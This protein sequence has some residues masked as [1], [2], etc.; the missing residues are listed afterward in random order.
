MEEFRFIL[1]RRV[2]IVLLSLVVFIGAF[3]A[4][5]AAGRALA[6]RPSPVDQE[7]SAASTD[8]VA[9]EALILAPSSPPIIVNSAIDTLVQE[10]HT[11]YGS[12]SVDRAYS[13]TT[14]SAGYV[15]VVGRSIDTWDG[16]G[17]ATPLHAHSNPD[18]V[19]FFVLKLAPGGSY[20]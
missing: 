4:V 13:V 1:G 2:L 9:G 8:P 19:D 16:P 3:I 10:W 14:D 12:E 7:A 20:I 5:P 11:F 18:Q 15:Y 6:A 17:T